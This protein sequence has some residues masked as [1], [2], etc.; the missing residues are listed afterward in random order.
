VTPPRSM[1]MRRSVSARMEAGPGAGR[2]VG[3]SRGSVLG[4]AV[5]RPPLFGRGPRHVG[6]GGHAGEGLGVVVARDHGAARDLRRIDTGQQKKLPVPHG[7]DLGVLGLRPRDEV[8]RIGDLVRGVEDKIDVVGERGAR[9]H[10]Q[11]A[12]EAL[13]LAPQPRILEKPCQMRFPR[14]CEHALGCLARLS[15]MQRFDVEAVVSGGFAA[16]PWRSRA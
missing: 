1:I 3:S 7:D 11:G 14:R 4:A 16:D 2:S 6:A 12:P 8:R 15:S 9:E 5:R 13:P 10:L